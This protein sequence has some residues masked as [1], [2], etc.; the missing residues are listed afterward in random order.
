MHNVVPIEEYQQTFH[1]SHRVMRPGFDKLSQVAPTVLNGTNED[2][3]VLVGTFHKCTQLSG[4]RSLSSGRADH[5]QSNQRCRHSHPAIR[6]ESHPFE[7]LWDFISAL[8]TRDASE[9]IQ[10]RA[11]LF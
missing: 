11:P 3:D 8:A 2:E 7:C 6:V 9:A 1:R 10:W 4:P 5:W